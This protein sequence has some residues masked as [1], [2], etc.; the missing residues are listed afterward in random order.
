MGGIIVLFVY[1]CTLIS[2]FKNSIK[3]SPTWLVPLFLVVFML[4]T[5]LFLRIWDFKLDIKNLFLSVI[6]INSNFLLILVIVTYLLWV[7]VISIKIC[8][9][10]KGGLKSKIYEF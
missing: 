2:N 6:Y 3:N 8:Q 4:S 10:F 7:L 5:I 9:K 1:V